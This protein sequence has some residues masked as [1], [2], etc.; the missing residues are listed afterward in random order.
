[1]HTNIALPIL[2]SAYTYRSIAALSE[3]KKE[4]QDEKNTIKASEQEKK[5]PRK[6]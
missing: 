1:M 2:F 6:K 5:S 3:I 4:V